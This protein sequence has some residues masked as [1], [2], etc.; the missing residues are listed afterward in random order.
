MEEYRKAIASPFHDAFIMK[1][2]DI[3][4]L[5][6]VIAALL[7]LRVEAA[8]RQP[9]PRAAAPGA[10][11]CR[12]SRYLDDLVRHCEIGYIRGLRATLAE[13]AA[14]DAAAQPFGRRDARASSRR[15]TCAG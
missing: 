9:A 8:S 13:I 10:R 3:G 6:E 14:A 4:R 1:P 15:S 11:T 7:G 12:R 5:V 2:V